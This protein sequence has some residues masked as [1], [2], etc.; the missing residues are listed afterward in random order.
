MDKTTSF[1]VIRITIIVILLTTKPVFG[2][3]FSAQKIVYENNVGDPRIFTA[4]LRNSD[5]ELAFPALPLGGDQKLE[6]VFDDLAEEQRYFSYTLI[7]C[8]IFWE[9]SDL[10]PQEYLTGI[11][12]G[13]VEE[14][15]TSFNTTVFFRHYRVQLPHPDC[16]PTLSGNYA[17]VVYESGNPNKVVLT[18]RLHLYENL[19]NLEGRFEPVDEPQSGLEV[20]QPRFSV[21]YPA[22]L[23]SDPLHDILPVIIQNECPLQVVLLDNPGYMEQGKLEYTHGTGKVFLAGNEFRSFDTRNLKYLSAEIDHYDFSGGLNQVYLKTDK[24]RD[25]G[26][27]FHRSD[28][29]GRYLIAK[30]KAVDPHVDSDYVVV[31]FSLEDPFMGEPTEVYV[32]GGFSDW[33]LD[34]KYRMTYNEALQLYSL[35]LLLKQGWYDYRYLALDTRNGQPVFDLIEGSFHETGNAYVALIYLRNQ[36]TPDRIIGIA[37]LS[38]KP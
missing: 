21:R 11:G 27:Y 15:G 12:E 17:L 1:I 31:H 19:A 33:S 3:A 2:F 32:T 26:R 10:T 24:N 7:H 34:E 13:T 30:E 16:M 20:Q 35:S 14:A 6:L 25:A 18:R 38:D 28:L 23:A 5:W 22:E 8:N 36:Q 9:A 4:M 29:N 37:K